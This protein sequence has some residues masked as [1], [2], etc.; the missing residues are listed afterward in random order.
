MCAW[1][2]WVPNVSKNCI[3][4]VVG[5]PSLK[6]SHGDSHVKYFYEF[7]INLKNEF[8]YNLLFKCL[9]NWL[10][11]EK[12]SMPGRNTSPFE[13]ESS[14]MLC[15]WSE[16]SLLVLHRCCSSDDCRWLGLADSSICH[17]ISCVDFYFIYF[18]SLLFFY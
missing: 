6:S 8:F 16:M 18:L 17:S 2:W 4:C 9:V 11:Y 7:E 10:I 5:S 13:V 15:V 3:C 1:L 12:R 14:A